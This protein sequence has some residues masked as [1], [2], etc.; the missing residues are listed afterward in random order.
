MISLEDC[1]G[2]CG[3]T[4]EEVLA[5]AEHEHLPEIAAAALAEYLASGAH[6]MERIRDMIV[7]DIRAAQDRQDKPHVLTLLHVL[8]HF[9]K[10]HPEIRPQ[11]HPWSRDAAPR[12]A[13]RS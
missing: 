10:T 3:L 13:P 7:E 9:L 4:E 6:G 1:I 5:I 12:T 8:H 2:M 11:H